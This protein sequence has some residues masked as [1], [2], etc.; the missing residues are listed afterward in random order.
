MAENIRSQH[1][2]KG[3]ENMTNSQIDDFELALLEF[4]KRASKQDA[5]AAEVEALPAIANA[6]IRLIEIA[7]F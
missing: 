1:S 3:G 5:T 6:L 7:G 2:E 4:V